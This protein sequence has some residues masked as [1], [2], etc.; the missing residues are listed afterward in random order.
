MAG[1]GWVLGARKLFINNKNTNKKEW[2]GGTSR[3]ENSIQ[4]QV[5]LCD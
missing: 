4:N 5:Q 3:S 2:R 1:G